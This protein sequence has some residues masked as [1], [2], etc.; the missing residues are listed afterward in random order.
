[1]VVGVEAVRVEARR[2]LARL[3]ADLDES[4]AAALIALTGRLDGRRRGVIEL[5]LSDG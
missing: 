1:L 2:A 4:Q 5:A 3:D